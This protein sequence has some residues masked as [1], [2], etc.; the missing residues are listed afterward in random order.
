[1]KKIFYIVCLVTMFMFIGEVKAEKTYKKCIY[2]IPKGRITKIEKDGGYTITLY[3]S[4][5]SKKLDTINIS[6]AIGGD[7]ELYSD[8][9]IGSNNTCPTITLDVSMLGNVRIYSSYKACVDDQSGFGDNTSGS[10]QTHIYSG[11]YESNAV[12]PGNGSERRQ[13]SLTNETSDT[14]QYTNKD[15]RFTINKNKKISCDRSDSD[16]TTFKNCTASFT[17]NVK[18][19]LFADSTI[20]PPYIYFKEIDVDIKPSTTTYKYEIDE[21]GQSADV[22][23]SESDKFGTEEGYGS[24]AKDEWITG[25][26]G[27]EEKEKVDPC[28]VINKNE[29][30]YKILK[31]IINY[32]Q[33]GTIFIVILLSG[34]DYIGAISSGNDDAMKKATGKTKNRIIALVLVFLVPAIVNLLLT[35][36]NVGACG[37][38]SDFISELFK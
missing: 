33:I 19:K 12:T 15:A 18:D 26:P 29:S 24:D 4:G 7:I 30:F 22:D 2:D 28:D 38:N 13:A 27:D 37:S 23:E 20:C 8:L 11:K 36:V 1:M 14:C 3:T 6:P 35:I 34:L 17:S 32:T 21:I 31:Q 25:H 5:K 9:S 16:Y 10:C